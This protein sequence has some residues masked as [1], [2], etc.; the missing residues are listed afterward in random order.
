M[1]MKFTDKAVEFLAQD[2]HKKMGGGMSLPEARIEA[3]RLLRC[4]VDLIEVEPVAMLIWCPMCHHRHIDRGDFATKP[5]RDHSCQKCGL[6]WR[7]AIVP[8]TGV[9]FLPGYKSDED[10]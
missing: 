4:L 1:N 3:D 2:L 7:P 9:P 10:P 5:H 6:T 8:T